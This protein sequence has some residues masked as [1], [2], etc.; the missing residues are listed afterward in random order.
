M[1]SL[2]SNQYSHDYATPIECIA[3]HNKGDRNRARGGVGAGE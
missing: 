2:F 3:E 1:I